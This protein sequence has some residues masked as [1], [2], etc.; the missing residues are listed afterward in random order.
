MTSL[1]SLS[2]AQPLWAFNLSI[3]NKKMCGRIAA[4]SVPSQKAVSPT[5]VQIR[6]EV[7]VFRVP[8]WHHSGSYVGVLLH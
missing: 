7:T 6:W 5:V 3:V 4:L 1:P 8:S 2:A